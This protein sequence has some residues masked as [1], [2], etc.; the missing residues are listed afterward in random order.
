MTTSVLLV[1]DHELIR[2]GLAGAFTRDESFT[3]AGQ[4]GTIADG[5]ALATSTQ[6]DVLVVDLQLPDGSGLDLVR[7]LRKERK[8]VGLVVLTMYAGDEQ[9]FAAMDAGASA[10]VGKDAP[11]TE[12]VAAARHAAVAPLSFTCAGLPEAM[13]RRMSSSSPRLSDRERQVLDLL[14]DGLGV[15]AIAAKLYISE[16]TAKTHI[17]KVYEKLGAANRAQALVAAMRA[18]LIDTSSPPR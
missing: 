9:I 13:M 16:S 11:S 15:A 4:A 5:L 7:A 1:D 2:H 12:V 10:F 18:G 14:A 17:A 3:V 6:P 8:D